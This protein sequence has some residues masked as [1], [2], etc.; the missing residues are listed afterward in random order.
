MKEV[1]PFNEDLLTA[2]DTDINYK[3]IQKGYKIYFEPEAI[4]FHQ[5]PQNHKSFRSKSKKYAIGKIQ[6]FRIHKNGLELWHLLPS[7]YFISGMFLSLI[8]FVNPWIGLGLA[9]YL[10]FY[11]LT[12]ILASIVQTIRFKQWKFLFMLPVMFVEGHMAWSAGILQEI[13]S[14]KKRRNEK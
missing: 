2:E 9:A 13:F 4:V 10:S 3:L 1:L 6:F 7:L 8:I 12:V 5:R 11:V 14:P